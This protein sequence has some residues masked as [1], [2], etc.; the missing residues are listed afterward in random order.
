M[1]IRDLAATFLGKERRRFNVKKQP[2][3][4]DSLIIDGNQSHFSFEHHTFGPFRANFA[5]Q[6]SGNSAAF[7][8]E[9]LSHTVPSLWKHETRVSECLEPWDEKRRLIRVI[10]TRN[11]LPQNIFLP[12]S[13]RQDLRTYFNDLNAKIL[14]QNKLAFALSG[15]HHLLCLSVWP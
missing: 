8:G 11:I 4:F 13:V 10:M 15:V 3:V 12:F 7:H 5:A 2:C 9:E 1:H 14:K 6:I